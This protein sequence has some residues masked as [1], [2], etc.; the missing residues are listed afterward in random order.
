M[1]K[2]TQVRICKDR[3]LWLDIG[4]TVAKYND[5]CLIEVDGD[6]YYAKIVS[7]IQEVADCICSKERGQIIRVATESDIS[8]IKDIFERE[9]KSLAI[10]LEKV[11]K[12][13]LPIRVIDAKCIHEGNKIIF[14]FVAEDRVDFRDLLKDIEH[15]LKTRIELRQVGV[16]DRAKNIAGYCGHCGRV[17]C[18]ASFIKEF[19]AVTIQNAKSQN[20]HLDPSKISGLCG[21]LMCC[22]RYESKSYQEM[23]KSFPKIDATVD[24]EYGQGKVVDLNIL[25]GSVTVELESGKRYE[26]KIK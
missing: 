12:H 23:K 14:H 8:Q 9:K 10:C 2:I 21:R 1:H 6:K 5:Y 15:T 22:L 18:C 16:R 3:T 13:N 25:R 24:T 7:G 26:H 11:A 17:L 19:Q 20:F 4:N